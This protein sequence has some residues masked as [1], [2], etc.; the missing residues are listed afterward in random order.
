MKVMDSPMDTE[1]CIVIT[2]KKKKMIQGLLPFQTL[3][4]P[5]TPNSLSNKK[6]KHMSPSPSETRSPKI[7]KVTRTENSENK[8]VSEVGLGTKDTRDEDI[9]D[10]TF[11]NPVEDSKNET[12]NEEAQLKE[13]KLDTKGETKDEK[14]VKKLEPSKFDE[15]S[16]EELAKELENL[17][18]DTERVKSDSSSDDHSD[19]DSVCGISSSDDDTDERRLNKEN[20]SQDDKKIVN[21]TNL[22]KT[23]TSGV[24]SESKNSA[25]RKLTPKQ[26]EKRMKSTKR[27]EEQR[28]KKLER[29]KQ[30]EEARLIRKKEKE[31]R[32]R[33]KK[34]KEEAEKEQ[35]RK[36]K[37]QK[38]LKKQMEIEQKQ[39]E[40]ERKDRAK[41][42]D[43]KK[44]EEAKE[45]EKRKKEE[46]RL[47]A[48]RKKQKAASTFASFFTPK[49]PEAKVVEEKKPVRISNF[50]P[51][52]VKVDMR[53]APVCR[54]SL[55][56][57]EKK[58]FDVVCI[59]KLDGTERLYVKEIKSREKRKCGKTWPPDSHD[60][61]TI[62]DEDEIG[63]C[64]VVN[65]PKPMVEK[66]R[67]KY[68]A[69][70][71]N[72]RPPYWGT[73]RKKSAT[74]TPRKP[75]S[76]DTKW[77]DYDVDSDE[78]WEEEEPGESLH[79]SDDEKEEE[80]PDDNEYDVDNEFMV[81]HGYLSEEEAQADDDEEDMSPETQKYKL[82][83]LGE[84]FEAERKT[85]PSKVKPRVIGCVWQGPSNAYPQN[86]SQKL[87]DFLTV[88]QAWVQATPI[89]LG[90]ANEGE[91]VD[92][93]G[94][95]TAETSEER[96]AVKEEAEDRR[97]GSKKKRLPAE[98][99][100]ELIRLIHGNTHGAGFLV[101]EFM[102]FWNRKKQD[103]GGSSPL[104]KSS[105]A[106]K[107]RELSKYMA[108]PE[109]GPMHLKVCWY[110]SPEIRKEYLGDESLE[111]PNKWNY[112]LVPKR[113][114][115]TE[116]EKTTEKPL[117]EDK[118]KEKEK[119]KEKK[120]VPL[121]TQY[122]KKI[123]QEEMKKQLDIKSSPISSPKAST[124][125]TKPP[126]RAQLISVARGQDFPNKSSIISAFSRT[127]NSND[128]ETVNVTPTIIDISDSGVIETTKTKVDEKSEPDVID[129]D[130]NPS[131]PTH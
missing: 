91:N 108:C 59:D 68:L 71:E 81:P 112:A 65:L 49:K 82:K 13:T 106:H 76:Q 120:S 53:V 110:V 11:E 101:K 69:F 103:D 8:K 130:S 6:R 90:T 47:E 54:R 75:F 19:S 88:R 16:N 58:E 32:R 9:V 123:T 94:E 124:S 98:A 107:I 34:E 12:D 95:E 39:K 118:E 61:V 43:R 96:E 40:K 87:V 127:Q 30:R 21:G 60:D 92:G 115:I 67:A 74:I 18:D 109:E 80:N 86:M 55:N 70:A 129:L 17:E 28:I 1:E 45:E 35:K 72:R 48:E 100:P 66:Q 77:F 117:K 20:E 27:R 85:Q 84:E 23:P 52:Q 105:I 46:E 122:T 111:L 114:A 41:E 79:G 57:S 121:I 5:T 10:I 131:L 42:E 44:R 29:E 14:K 3:G 22:D 125:Q 36:E 37:E 4:T 56:E 26:L 15:S 33:E 25:N 31:A 83:I 89:I 93:D 113:K 73:W 63:G 78:E 64:D 102:T 97:G 99:L 126:K 104:L 62:I 116:T 128:P 2:P 50:M 119:E 24:K 38:E 51:F 7:V